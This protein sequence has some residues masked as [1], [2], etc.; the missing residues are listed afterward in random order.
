M[1][2]WLKILHIATLS[3]WCAGLLGLPLLYA[4]RPLV[5]EGG[6]LFE[7]QAFT[8]FLF[9]TLVSPAAFLAIG[10]GTALIFLRDTFT[11]WFA[12]KLLA[13]GVLALLHLLNG[14]VVLHLFG[15]PHLLWRGANAGLTGL[16]LLTI[17]AILWLVLD[18][19][20][21]GLDAVPDVLRR[22]GG[23]RDLLGWLAPSFSRAT[24]P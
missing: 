21:A 17:L 2:L 7:L 19:P 14:Y 15:N 3:V 18:K 13:V 20:A 12:A 23:L 8:R 1:I 22:P 9:V 6:P 5:A 10:S 24:T 4:R 16:T 11:L